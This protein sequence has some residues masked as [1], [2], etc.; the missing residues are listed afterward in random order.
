MRESNTSTNVRFMS[1]FVQKKCFSRWNWRKPS[2][3]YSLLS[4][5]PR[6]PK[7]CPFNRGVRLR[8]IFFFIC[9]TYDVYYN[10]SLVSDYDE[11]ETE[12][13]G[14]ATS[15]AFDLIRRS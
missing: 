7:L 15:F 9:D 2:T 5:Q 10:L 6:F 14:N 12:N 13:F 3:V 8:G 4:G 11:N 1:P